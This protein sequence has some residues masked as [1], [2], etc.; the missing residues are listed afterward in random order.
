MRISA[1]IRTL[2]SGRLVKSSHRG[3]LVWKSTWRKI[4]QKMQ[5]KGIFQK[6]EFRYLLQSTLGDFQGCREKPGF[7]KKLLHLIKFLRHP[8]SKGG[9]K[10]E[11]NWDQ[12]Y[13]R[14]DDA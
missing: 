11:L 5:K 14:F 1:K 6:S 10:L 8:T 12:C 9:L 13:L 3:R 4:L 2:V 7:L